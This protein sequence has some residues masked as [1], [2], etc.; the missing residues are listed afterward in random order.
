M[1]TKKAV[2]CLSKLQTRFTQM[3]TTNIEFF[4]M[5]HRRSRAGSSDL[6][7]VSEFFGLVLNLLLLD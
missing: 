7:L 1:R 5:R 2:S 4:F 3:L 6:E